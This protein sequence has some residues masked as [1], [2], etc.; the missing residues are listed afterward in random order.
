MSSR[1]GSVVMEAP[2]DEAEPS[3]ASFDSQTVKTTETRGN[4]AMTVASRSVAE[5]DISP[6]IPWNC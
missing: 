4:E 6:L 2:S 1:G 3:A 5:N